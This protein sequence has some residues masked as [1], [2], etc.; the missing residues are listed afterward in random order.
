[1]SS[2]PSITAV[3]DLAS[4]L[5]FVQTSA[6][7]QH[8]ATL[9]VYPSVADVLREL[10]ENGVDRFI[11]CSSAVPKEE[12]RA[13]LA[14]RLPELADALVL[15]RDGLGDLLA[16][17]AER[18]VDGVKLLFVG[19]EAADREIVRNAGILTAPHPRLA[20]PVLRGDGPLRYLRIRVPLLE[21]TIDWV[22]ALRAERVVPLHLTT[23]PGA[24]APTIYAIADTRTTAA[25]D[26]LG[27]WVDRLGAPDEPQTT[28]IFLIRDA[29]HEQHGF[30]EPIGNASSMFASE[31]AA[32]RVLA[33][34]HEGFLVALPGNARVDKLRFADSFDGHTHRRTPSLTL[35]QRGCTVAP[36]ATELTRA[37][38]AEPLSTDEQDVLRRHFRPDFMETTVARYAGTAPGAGFDSRNV[39]H[40]GNQLAVDALIAELERV[41]PGRLKVERH[42]FAQDTLTNVVATLPAA[43][44]REKEGIVFISAHLDS[45][46]DCEIDYDP[47]TWPAPGADDDGSGMAAV[48]AA[49]HAFV[50]LSKLRPHREVRF[51]FFNSE[52]IDK[53]GSETYT[54]SQ[55][56]LCKQVTAAFH[57][58]MI[59]YDQKPPAVFEVHAGYAATK[60]KDAKAAAARSA[61]Q[62]D[63]I[64]YLRPIVTTLPKTEITTSPDE[65]GAGRSDHCMFHAA[66][67]P[68]CWVTED[69]FPESGK[70]S[71][72]NPAYHTRKDLTI[73]ADYAAQIARLV[74]AAAWIA[75]TR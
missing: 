57:L 45:T 47:E 13:T 18:R 36:R 1:M 66:G 26:D 71:D 44:G 7:G 24:C 29:L 34:T 53:A 14:E 38:A 46:A 67:Y 49:A 55:A 70:R 63:L 48:L 68:A 42:G 62:A 20:L 19:A 12:V 61:E 73:K 27:F 25:L 11:V 65:S 40:E 64:E 58:D 17:A 60:P 52:E 37:A 15:G 56:A 8:I 10:M 30:L 22:Y 4:T 3:F 59:G 5:A 32:S 23:E 31:P 69:F 50:E 43:A 54:N 41:D 51:A 9:E 72:K 39:Y 16:Q 75:A 2:T 74:G 28:A 6:D 33:S 21:Q 35:L